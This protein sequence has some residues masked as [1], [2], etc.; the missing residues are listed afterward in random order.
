MALAKA[1]TTL[2]QQCPPVPQE[3]FPA[4]NDAYI[5]INLLNKANAIAPGVATFIASAAI[6]K[7][8]AVNINTG[9]ARHADKDLSR[10]ALG[11]ALNSAAIGEKV[12][13]LIGTGYVS[14]LIGLT[15]NSAVY[16]GATGTLSFSIPGAGL[17]QSIGYALSTTELFVTVSMPF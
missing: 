9:Q 13:V 6:T 17:K 7:G 12:S 11:I 3:V 2:P 4:I 10:P 16:L 15:A 5:A 14:G 1:N 8:R